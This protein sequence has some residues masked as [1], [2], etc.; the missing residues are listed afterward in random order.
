MPALTRRRDRDA[1]QETWLIFYDGD[2]RA[3][4][5]ALRSG[6]PTT[7]EPWEWSCGFYW[8]SG[9]RLRLGHR[10]DILG[11]TQGLRGG[12]EDLP[13]K[14]RWGRFSGLARP[15]RPDRTEYALF[16]AG[17]RPPSPE[18]EPGKPCDTRMKCRCGEVFDSHD[19][20]GSYIHRGHI[21]QQQAGRNR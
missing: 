20:A 19:P 5:V 17:L 18:W 21:Y 2:I 14:T 10:G 11:S 16:D 8:L 3:G 7:T 12:M 1:S 4:T 15:A 13:R 6:Q 9:G